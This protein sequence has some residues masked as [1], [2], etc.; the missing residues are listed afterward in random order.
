MIYALA[1]VCLPPFR[2]SIV[3]DAARDGGAIF[4]TVVLHCTSALRVL[5]NLHTRDIEAHSTSNIFR[6][7][8][9]NL[10]LLYG[11]HW[12]RGSDVVVNNDLLLRYE[13][14][15]PTVP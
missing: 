11:L 6:T 13:N 2:S 12:I 3:H 4:D 10:L 14:L 15:V 9:W 1:L 5:Y 7:K 8:V